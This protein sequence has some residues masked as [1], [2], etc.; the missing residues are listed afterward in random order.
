MY[1]RRGETGRVD[2]VLGDLVGE[3]HERNPTAAEIRRSVDTPLVLAEGERRKK[4][5]APPTMPC[6]RNWVAPW[7]TTPGASGAIRTMLLVRTG[8]SIISRVAKALPLLTVLVSRIGGSAVM[9]ID[10]LTPPTSILILILI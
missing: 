8:R 4:A 3:G 7:F 9:V 2:L 1:N 10:S 5:R 6:V